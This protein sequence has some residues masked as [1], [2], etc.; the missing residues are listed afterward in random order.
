MRMRNRLSKC[1]KHLAFATCMLALGGSFSACQDE[2]YLDEEKPTWLN[3]SIYETLESS[4]IYKNYLRLI[5]DPDVNVEGDENASLKEILKRTGSKTVFVADDQAWDD[6]FKGN[7]AL[8][9]VNPWH[10][11]T[12]YDKLTKSQKKLLLH[13]SMLNNAIVMEN[14]ASSSGN[15]PTRGAYIR[16]QTDV[17][18]VDSVACIAVEDL[19]KS[20][21]SADRQTSE[22]NAALV[23]VDQWGRIRNGGLLNYSSIYLVQDNTRPMM[24][25]FTNE[26]MSKNLI[27]DNDFKIITGQ[28]RVTGDIHI[29]N[30]RLDSAD[31]VCENGYVNK[32]HRPLVPLS[33]MAE[34]IRTSGKTHIFSHMLERFSVPVQNTTEALLFARL[35]PTKF[36]DTDTLYTKRYYSLRS[37]GGEKF[38]KNERGEVFGGTGEALLKFDPG[39][40][41]YFPATAKTPE[42]DMGAMFIPNDKQML[43]FFGKGD[44]ATLIKEYA[45]DPSWNYSLENLTKLYEDIDQIPLSKLATILSHCMQES[46][47]ASVPSKMSSLREESTLEQLYTPGDIKKIEDVLLACNGVVYVMDDIKIPSD[48]S[49]VATPAFLRSTNKIMSWAIY[50]DQKASNTGMNLHYYAFLK[51]MQSRFSFFMPSDAALGYYY[52]PMSFSSTYP[53]ML[54]FKYI[55]T[56]SENA[57]PISIKKEDN[58]NYTY[59]INTGEIGASNLASSFA[60]VDFT[61]RLRQILEGSTIVHTGS[62]NKINDEENEYYVAKNGMGIRV[63]REGGRVVRA[64]GGFQLENQRAGLSATAPGIIYCNVDLTENT[65]FKNGYTFTM[66]APLIPAARSVFGVLSNMP[67]GAEGVPADYSEQTADTNPFYEFFKLCND[68][69]E[70]LILGSGLVDES[71]YNEDIHKEAQAKQRAL[72]LYKTFLSDNTVDQR[73]Q[74]FN[75]YNYTILAPSNEAILAAVEL[76]LPTWESIDRDYRLLDDDPENDTDLEKDLGDLTTKEDSLNIQAK[77]VYLTNFVRSHFVDKSYFADKATMSEEDIFSSSFSRETGMFVKHKAKRDQSGVLSVNDT[78][79]GNWINSISESHQ[80]VTQNIMTCDRELSGEV[81][82]S[83]NKSGNL[84]GIKLEGASYAVVHLMDGVLNF[85]ELKDGRY[86]DFEDVMEARR[87]IKQFEIR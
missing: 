5:E 74:F 49:C 20:Y 48:F 66:D 1:S 65:K 78:Y 81:K 61:D 59:D 58:I 73:V 79:G 43:E 29:N 72:N 6:F 26:F 35:N 60:K 21:W 34:A 82:T 47:V 46:F 8:P 25:Q 54:K 64:Q 13:T 41:G 27:T 3:T 28:E 85:K 39:W 14:L 2:Y 76:G 12:S 50:C 10:T 42:E 33:N 31:I 86:E 4:G 55:K 22:E 11:A 77:I 51:A 36:K 62:E 32:T 75:N 18:I 83:A 68:Y 87:F 17:E 37:F 56:E 69:D 80:L 15:N 24:L 38:D 63:E 57:F 53:R 70:G 9:T 7:E 16:R 19:P 30:H 67:K 23:E 45:K 44:G 84:S 71:E 40:N 52:D